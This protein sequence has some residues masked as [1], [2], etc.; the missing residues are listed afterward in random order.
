MNVSLKRQDQ[1]WLE[2]Q[3]AAGRFT[4]VAEAVASALAKLK[5]DDRIDDQWAKPLVDDALTALDRG[6]RT[7]WTKGVALRTIKA[8]R[9]G[10]A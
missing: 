4:S 6:E 3:V 8:S 2:A 9:T 10:G 7:L 1:E 5:S